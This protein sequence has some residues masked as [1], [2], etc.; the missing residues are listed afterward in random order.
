MKKEYDIALS[1]YQR[2]SLIM[3]EFL[4]SPDLVRYFIRRLKHIENESS[5]KDHL[6]MRLSI[7]FIKSG[8]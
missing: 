5:R 6:E 4:R 1:N 2:I 8:G 3:I 7:K